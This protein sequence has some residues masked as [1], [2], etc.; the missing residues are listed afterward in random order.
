MGRLILGI[1]LGM[2]AAVATILVVELAAY[3]LYS[4]PDGL[5]MDSHEQMGAYIMGMPSGAHALVAFAWFAGAADGGLVAALVSRRHWTIWLI[6]A[7]V[8]AAGLYNILTYSHPLL[9]Q[10]AA[11]LAPL[12][13]GFVASLVDRK[14]FAAGQGSTG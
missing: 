11:L 2:V 5:D 14:R 12:L 9:L 13:G 8:I 4:P 1:F 7:L 10:F 6:A 3:F